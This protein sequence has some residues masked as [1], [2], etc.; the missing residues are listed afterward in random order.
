MHA[1]VIA[2]VL[3]GSFDD[4]ASFSITILDWMDYSFSVAEVRI[5]HHVYA[6]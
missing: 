1:E 3:T 4:F 5:S 2:L 6:L